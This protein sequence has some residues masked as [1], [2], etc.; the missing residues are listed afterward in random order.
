M[1][2]AQKDTIYID[3]DD[4]ITGIIDKLLASRQKIVA[5]VLPKRAAVLQSIV[6]MKLLKRTA[7]EAGK[8]IVLI[9]SEAGLLPLAGAVGVHVAKTLQS[10]PTLP[11][12]PSVKDTPLTVSEDEVGDVSDSDLDPTKPV[13]ELAG[14]PADNDDE[15]IEVDNDDEAAAP[16]TAA[17]AKKPFN[18]KLKIPNF[19]KFRV[20]LFLGILALI[21]LL[22]G[23]YFA[24]FV[25]PKARVTIKTDT[26]DV[27]TNLDITARPKIDTVDEEKKIVPAEV[28]ELKKTDSQKVPATGEKDMGTKATGKVTFALSDCSVDQV[29]IPAGTGVSSNN[30][31]FITQQDIALKSVKIGNSCMNSSFKEFSTGTTSVVAQNAGDKYNLSQRSYSVSGFNNVTAS[32]TDMTGGTSKIVKVVSQQDVDGAKQKILDQN[33]QVATDE[34]TKQLEA[35]GFYPLKDTFTAGD[36]LVA[37]TPNVGDEASDVTVNVTVTYT[38]AGAKEDGL[39]QLIENDAKQH[40]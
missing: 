15:T 3:V 22:V 8:K 30:L 12:A 16:A 17:T 13:G 36:P 5:L 10:R 2:S 11:A 6:N 21:L 31:T 33:T 25:A 32:G 24:Y 39:K 14:L 28:K 26:S 1:S 18:R 29:N 19:E 37:T 27:T 34:V 7:D 20:R 4:E 23:W 35:D 38:M 9:T 40:I